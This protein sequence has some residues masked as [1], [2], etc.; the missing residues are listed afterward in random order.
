LESLPRRADGLMAVPVQQGPIDLAITWTTTPDLLAGRWLSAISL[1]L[2]TLLCSFERKR[3][4]PG[5]S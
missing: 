1:L 4:R 5:L 3:P 2:L